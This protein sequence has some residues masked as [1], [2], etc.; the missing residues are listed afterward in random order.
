MKPGQVLI[1]T[2]ALGTGTLF[3]ADMR[4]KAKGRWIDEAVHSMLLSNQEAAIA[5]MKHGATACTDVTGFGL[6]GHLL[7]M[8]KASG[9]AVE[10]N[11]EAIPVL[12]GALETLQLGITS[13]LHPQNLRASFYIRNLSEVS[14]SPKYSI[15]FD[16]QTSGGLLAT[17]SSEQADAC[18]AA[19]KAQGYPHSQIIGR[20]L[21]ATDGI[22]PIAIAS[23]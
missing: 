17:V 7:E 15:L 12:E 22:Q 23:I 14:V 2:K 19:L 20:V 1:L 9:V 3:A 8:V 6:L 21:P 4:L 5:F 10:L 18:L 11:L 13:S 16:P